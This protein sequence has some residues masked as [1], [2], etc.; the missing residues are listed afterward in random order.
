MLQQGSMIN[1]KI[2][3]SCGRYKQIR[4]CLLLRIGG[5]IEGTFWGDENV[6]KQDYIN[7]T[8]T[9]N[10]LKMIKVYIRNSCI[11]WYVRFAIRQPETLTDC[12]QKES[13]VY[14]VPLENC[15]AVSNQIRTWMCTP[16]CCHWTRGIIP[17]RDVS[18]CSSKSTVKDS[19]H[20]QSV[21][22]MH[23]FTDTKMDE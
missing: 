15:W 1:L 23:T 13:T 19:H 16:G 7:R 22:T 4:D 6:L 8:I 2:L 12:W 3:T 21:E 20:C 14:A 5:K 10:L 11:L 18:R 17:N 9:L